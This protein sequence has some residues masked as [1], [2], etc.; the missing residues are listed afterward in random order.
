MRR[1]I[2]LFAIIII[3]SCGITKTLQYYPCPVQKEMY[4]DSIT[5]HTDTLYIKSRIEE[6]HP[7][8]VQHIDT[9]FFCTNTVHA[10]ISIYNGGSLLKIYKNAIIEIYGGYYKNGKIILTTT[11][12]HYSEDNGH[13]SFLD[14][15]GKKV[16]IQSNNFIIDNRHISYKESAHSIDTTLETKYRLT[17]RDTIYPRMKIMADTIRVFNGFR[18]ATKKEIIEEYQNLKR[19]R[20]RYTN[21]LRIMNPNDTFYFIKKNEIYEINKKM[22][23]IERYLRRVNVFSDNLYSQII[24]YS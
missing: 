12:Y 16:E 1:F 21:E 23:E 5:Y 10:N 8:I 6:T 14:A 11:S 3:S 2:Y 22:R 15:A 17:Y 9:N 24:V 13:L 7:Y 20:D 18:N 19:R 4:K